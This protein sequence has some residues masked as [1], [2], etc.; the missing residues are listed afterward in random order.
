MRLRANELSMVIDRQPIVSGVDITVGPGEVVGL[1]GPNGSGKSTLLRGVYRVLRPDAGRAEID[2]Y[3][4]WALSAKAAARRVA[5]LV[6][7]PAGDVDFDVREIV[8]MGRSPYLSALRPATAADEQLVTDALERVGA[9]PLAGRGF[10][11]LS[12]GEKQRVL[13]ARALA[14]QPDLLVLDEPTNHLDVRHQLETLDLMRRLGIATLTA[15][16]DLNLA[17]AYCDR[18]YVL[19]AGRVVA[20]GPPDEVLSPELV[21]TVFGVGAVPSVH[22]VTGRTHLAFY[23]LP[24]AAETA[25]V[26][27]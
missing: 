20:S 12:G 18:L 4:V 17:A 26:R 16:H 27:R 22:P 24:A 2:G 15:L 3:D 6:Q 25:T 23:P 5:A 8:R 11:T 7:E 19:A 21:G 14:Q 13:L 9:M 1:V 10:R